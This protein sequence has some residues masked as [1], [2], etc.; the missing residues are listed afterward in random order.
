M[1]KN[2]SREWTDGL[3]GIKTATNPK[4]GGRVRGRD[5]SYLSNY[6]GGLSERRLSYSRMRAQAKYRNEQFTLTWEEY[7]QLWE[8]QWHLRGREPNQLCLTRIDLDGEWSQANIEIITR[9]EHWAKQARM[10]PS[11]K[12]IKRGPYRPRAVDNEN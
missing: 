7:Q 6:S 9:N 2:K 5:Y 10:R 3:Q 12:G 11:Q 4:G 8:G 1:A